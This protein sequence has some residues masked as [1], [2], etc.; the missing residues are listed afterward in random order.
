MYGTVARLNNK[1]NTAV[2]LPGTKVNALPNA[3][4]DSKGVELGI[5][6]FF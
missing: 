2:S 6:H 4:G 5:R 1:D 3:G